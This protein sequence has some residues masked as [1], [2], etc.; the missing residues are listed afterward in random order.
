MARASPFSQT[1]RGEISLERSRRARKSPSW[2]SPSVVEE[3]PSARISVPERSRGQHFQFF[4]EF[5][6]NIW[7]HILFFRKNVAKVEILRYLGCA[8][9]LK[10]MRNRMRMRIA[11]LTRHSPF[12]TRHSPLKKAP[13][14]PRA[15]LHDRRDDTTRTCDH[16]PPRRVLYQLS[17]I[18]IYLKFRRPL[19]SSRA[20]K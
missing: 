17:Y 12:A 2:R 9:R 16:T 15:F 6:A 11:H 10:R 14:F 18:P 20:R 1:S 3:L 4:L 13:G 8:L 19:P 5:V 7:Q